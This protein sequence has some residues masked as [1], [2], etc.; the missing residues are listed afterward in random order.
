M[1]QFPLVQNHNCS[2][3]NVSQ[4]WKI[5]EI[6]V[7]VLRVLSKDRFRILVHFLG[8][9]Y[10]GNVHGTSVGD[11]RCQAAAQFSLH[12]RRCSQQDPFFLTGPIINL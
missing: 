11:A 12:L 2:L 1:E 7:N 5:L 4:P 10:F 9:P 3:I 8:W 6:I